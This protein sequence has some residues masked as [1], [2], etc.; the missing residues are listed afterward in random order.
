MLNFVKY[1]SHFL[2]FFL[3]LQTHKI[4]PPVHL[5]SGVRDLQSH[6]LIYHT[7]IGVRTYEA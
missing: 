6:L 2:I 5:D 1:C 4:W 7:P 3:S